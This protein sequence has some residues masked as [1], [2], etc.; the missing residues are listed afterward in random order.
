M[1]YSASVRELG[2][3]ETTLLY[4]F[5]NWSKNNE[6]PGQSSGRNEISWASYRIYAVSYTHLDVYKRQLF[7]DVTVIHSVKMFQ[8]F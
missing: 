7:G 4:G 8:L 2:E 3:M 1:Q 5:K 6:I